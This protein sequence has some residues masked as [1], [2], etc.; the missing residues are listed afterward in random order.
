M[1]LSHDGSSGAPPPG[2][3]DPVSILGS[4]GP[5]MQETAINAILLLR[6]QMRRYPPINFFWN[7]MHH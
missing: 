6:L 5:Q 1:L 4:R 7:W 2:G 3:S